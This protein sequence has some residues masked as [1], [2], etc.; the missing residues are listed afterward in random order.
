MRNIIEEVN[1]IIEFEFAKMECFLCPTRT[2]NRCHIC[3]LPVCDEHRHMAAGA[4]I[5]KIRCILCQKY[6]HR[7]AFGEL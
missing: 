4:F 5:P 1:N 3:E 2:E 7:T 6:V